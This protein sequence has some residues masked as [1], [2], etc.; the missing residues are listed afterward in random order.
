M[1]SPWIGV[2]DSVL[3]D[4]AQLILSRASALTQL[5][6][7]WLLR[8]LLTVSLTPSICIG[9]TSEEENQTA[10]FRS[11]ASSSQFLFHTTASSLLWLPLH[12][13]WHSSNAPG[14]GR[15]LSASCS[16]LEASPVGG[17]TGETGGI[18]KPGGTVNPGPAAAA[19]GD[20]LGEL[21]ARTL[22]I[23]SKRR[24]KKAVKSRG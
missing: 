24:G 14:L 16:C 17:M 11:R 20:G 12:L 13:R 21:A 15:P 18:P 22:P 7:K 5:T 9:K 4:G 1:S 23:L 3:K 8:P 19:G 2:G 6:W 10:L